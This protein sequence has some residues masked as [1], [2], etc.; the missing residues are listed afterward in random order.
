MNHLRCFHTQFNVF[1]HQLTLNFCIWY[2]CSR[3]KGSCWGTS[4]GIKLTNS[5]SRWLLCLRNCS[6]STFPFMTVNPQQ[7]LR[8]RKS[9]HKWVLRS[10]FY[11]QQ[12]ITAYLTSSVGDGVKQR[13][14]G[15]LWLTDS[16]QKVSENG[17]G[18]R[19]SLYACCHSS[20]STAY[21]NLIIFFRSL[22]ICWPLQPKIEQKRFL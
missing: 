15:L 21:S 14:Y 8:Q 18:S 4:L 7:T 9:N 10:A 12:Q 20:K 16:T 11:S 3:G 13:S 2:K 22:I 5:N 1:S 17:K 6:R 19:L